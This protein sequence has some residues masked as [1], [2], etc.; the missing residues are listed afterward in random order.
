MPPILA[1][2]AAASQMGAGTC[3]R[4]IRLCRHES[5]SCRSSPSFCLKLSFASI[6][7]PIAFICNEDYRKH[8]AE[9]THSCRS[10]T[11]ISLVDPIP[12]LFLSLDSLATSRNKVFG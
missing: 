4:Q 5:I 2:S 11:S 6:D 7:S 10:N 3:P 1:N 12:Y 8:L 9:V